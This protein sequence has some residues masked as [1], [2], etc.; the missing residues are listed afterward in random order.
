MVDRH[1]TNDIFAITLFLNDVILAIARSVQCYNVCLKAKNI[2]LKTNIKKSKY[3][4]VN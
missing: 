1:M 2:C 4:S 3:F